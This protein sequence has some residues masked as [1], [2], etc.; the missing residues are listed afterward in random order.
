[1]K[2]LLNRLEPVGLIAGS[3]RLPFMVASAVR[4]TQRPLVVVGLRGFANPRLADQADDFVWGGLTRLGG[5]IRALRR[6]GVREAVMIGGVRKKAI[7]SPLRLVRYIPDLR[8]ARLWYV[9]VRKDKRDNAVL[10]AAAEEL[11][12]EGI[13]LVSSVDYCREHLA[14]EGLMTRTPVPRGAE[15]DVEFGWKIARS[16]ADLDIGQSVAVKERDIIAIEAMEGTD[17]MIRRTG[18]LCRV[19]GWTMVKVARSKQD[20]RFDVPTVGPETIRNLK[21]A[22]CACLVLEAGKTLI[23]DKPSTLALADKLKLAVI[24]RLS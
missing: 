3:G 19:G 20:M 13:T 22:K 7:Y 2:K 11:Q 15:D 5:W 9:K 16:S 18:R 12:S 10:L 14:D 6:R 24:G 4:K 1:M 23:V 17:S 8:T 21:D